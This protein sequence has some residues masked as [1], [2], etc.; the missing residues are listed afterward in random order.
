M[1]YVGS[2]CENENQYTC[3]EDVLELLNSAERSAVIKHLDTRFYIKPDRMTHLNLIKW[4]YIK[5]RSKSER[6]E[7]TIESGLHHVFGDVLQEEIETFSKVSG[8][9]ETSLMQQ[10]LLKHLTGVKEFDSWE[11]DTQT[12]LYIR[13]K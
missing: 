11:L 4:A 13:K 7:H 1:L 12:N 2:H 9:D 10:A 8:L 6:A 3:M 5:G